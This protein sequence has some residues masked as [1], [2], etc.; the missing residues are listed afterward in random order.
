MAQRDGGLRCA[1]LAALQMD[2]GYII[3]FV[4]VGLVAFYAL[5]MAVYLLNK[6]QRAAK[7]HPAACGCCPSLRSRTV[8]DP[9]AAPPA[10]E[11]PFVWVGSEVGRKLWQD[12]ASLAKL[13]QHGLVESRLK[14]Q[15]IFRPMHWW[16]HE[17][18][19][20]A[21]KKRRR[22]N[23]MMN[24][25]RVAANSLPAPSM[26]TGARRSMMNLFEPQQPKDAWVPPPPRV[27]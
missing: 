16:A 24:G 20:A 3:L 1:R 7:T 23:M 21:E 18:P 27:V 13:R 8:P 22:G 9:P 10:T 2:N 19:K 17:D 4:V 26:A 5:L 11:A 15:N 12:K 6:R 25:F 14:V